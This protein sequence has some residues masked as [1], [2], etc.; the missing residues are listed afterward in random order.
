[1]MA[2]NARDREAVDRLRPALLGLITPET[3]AKTLG[4]IH[5]YLA[6]DAY[7]EGRMDEAVEHA[8]R[9]AE[10]AEEI[11]HDYLL[12]SAHCTRM[13]AQSARDGAIP[14]AALVELLELTGRTMVKTD[15][16]YALW[17]VA[18]YAAAVEPETA[19]R[20]LALAEPIRAEFDLEIWPEGEL[21]DETM[22]ILGI[23]DLQPLVA[24]TDPLDH[25][26]A[27]A[28]AVAWLAGR[29]PAEQAPRAMPTRVAT[30]AG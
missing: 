12:G 20:W 25:T 17:W 13:L 5:Y 3:S 19:G 7:A 4:W 23:D 1:M 8:S 30:S 27:F 2:G 21:R 24:A 10:L 16:V 22:A 29:D 15:V 6:N 26:A 18:R 28:E 11:G 9:S 14:Q